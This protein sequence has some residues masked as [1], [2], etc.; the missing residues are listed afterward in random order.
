MKKK[1]RKERCRCKTNSRLARY[2]DTGSKS[3]N[4]YK[5]C[6]I[7]ERVDFK[8]DYEPGQKEQLY[9]HYLERAEKYPQFSCPK[10]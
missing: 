4:Y 1:V 5:P 7:H 10:N 8:S 6:P 3:I 2:G 9:K